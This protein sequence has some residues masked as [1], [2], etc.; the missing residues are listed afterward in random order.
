MFFMLYQGTSPRVPI[1]LEICISGSVSE[2]Q[3]DKP[4]HD[5]PVLIPSGLGGGSP[6]LFVI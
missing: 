1:K 4:M 2:N 3:G 6:G 5:E